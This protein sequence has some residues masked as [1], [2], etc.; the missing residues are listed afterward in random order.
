VEEEVKEE[1]VVKR[2]EPIR[3]ELGKLQEEAKKIDS[4]LKEKLQ[5]IE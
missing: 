5:V 4:K 2:S 1:E 3:E